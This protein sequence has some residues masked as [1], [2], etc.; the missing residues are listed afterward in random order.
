M[1]KETFA[2]IIRRNRWRELRDKINLYTV[3]GW[4]MVSIS[5]ASGD[6]LILF[7]RDPQ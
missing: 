7:E 1:D 2:I 5:R 3:Q 4:S 6:A